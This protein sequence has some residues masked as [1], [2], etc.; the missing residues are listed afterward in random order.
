M[1]RRML[2]RMGEGRF[3]VVTADGSPAVSFDIER[4]VIE[5]AGATLESQAR[6]Y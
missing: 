2:A 1:P 3:L 6:D 5:A 4:E